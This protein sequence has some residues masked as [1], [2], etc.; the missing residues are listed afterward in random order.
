LV[1]KISIRGE[2]TKRFDDFF[3]YFSVQFI[4]TFRFLAFL[5]KGRTFAVRNKMNITI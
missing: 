5:K 3:R 2:S 4:I 1:A